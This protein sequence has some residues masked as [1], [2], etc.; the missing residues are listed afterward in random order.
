MF[1]FH[2]HWM[3]D[4]L[5]CGSGWI[6]KPEGEWR[7]RGRRGGEKRGEERE[8]ERERLAPKQICCEV[9]MAENLKKVD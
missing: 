5:R 7:G 3:L 4:C 8:R 2:E 1:A 9:T 6:Q